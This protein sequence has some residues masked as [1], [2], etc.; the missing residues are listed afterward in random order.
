MKLKRAWNAIVHRYKNFD[1]PKVEHHCDAE[2]NCY[3]R[4]INRMTGRS[5][6]FGSEQEVRIWLDQQHY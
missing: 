2:G 6:T 4:A 1:E 3:Y 5:N